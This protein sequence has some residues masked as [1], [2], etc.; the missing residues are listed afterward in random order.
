[1]T[2]ATINRRFAAAKRRY[3]AAKPRSRAKIVQH[4]EMVL[5]R[6]QQLKAA[7]REERR[8]R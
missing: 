4:R 8:E 3:D 6:V 7:C 5:Y 2:P 1:M